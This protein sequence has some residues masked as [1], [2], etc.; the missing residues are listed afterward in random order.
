[1]D[2]DVAITASNKGLENPP[3]LI[4]MSL[5]ENAWNFVQHSKL[6][7]YYFSF[8]KAKDAVV[9]GIGSAFTPAISLFYG[10]QQAI[11]EIRQ[12]GIEKIWD[13]HRKL[14]DAFRKT[15]EFLGLKILPPNPSDS[16]TVIEIPV[17]FS[18]N[19]IVTELK[20]K[21]G[22][23]ISK[24]QSILNDRVIRIGH[25]GRVDLKADAELIAALEDV[26]RDSGVK[27]THTNTCD[28]FLK[29]AKF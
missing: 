27:L 3:G 23:I 19:K 8:Q 12:Q 10:M 21:Y 29:Y 7:T 15:V 20:R 17:D 5:N 16:V 24:G 4:F 18:A 14:A 13:D 22:Y 11:A 9:K 25:L 26:L 2:I 28:Y 1:W 6:S